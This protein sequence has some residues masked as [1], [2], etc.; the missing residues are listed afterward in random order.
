M[1]SVYGTCFFKA[2]PVWQSFYTHHNLLFTLI[3]VVA[4]MKQQSTTGELLLYWSLATVDQT[5]D[6]VVT[7]ETILSK[8]EYS[9]CNYTYTNVS[10][11]HN[12]IYSKSRL[13]L[14][15]GG[16][17][18]RTWRKSCAKKCLPFSVKNFSLAFISVFL[19]LPM[20]S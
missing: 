11:S 8:S 12:N 20:P 18:L 3:V 19:I 7:T 15:F 14:M 17:S 1:S 2:L 9:L 4:P 5:D 10:T 6:G 16:L 13:T